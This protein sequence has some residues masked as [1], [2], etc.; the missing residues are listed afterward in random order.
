[1]AHGRIV[2]RASPGRKFQNFLRPLS[3][4]PPKCKLSTVTLFAHAECRKERVLQQDGEIRCN[5]KAVK[6]T[7]VV[8]QIS[9]ARVCGKKDIVVT[10]L[11][12]QPLRSQ[13][14][15]EKMVSQSK[16]TEPIGKGERRRV[17]VTRGEPKGCN[18]PGYNSN[19]L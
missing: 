19:N 7:R 12:C 13:V 2:D 15:G 3:V 8:K 6:E 5:A 9:A 11:I 18:E 17:G 10:P 1:M 4:K 16:E 14:R